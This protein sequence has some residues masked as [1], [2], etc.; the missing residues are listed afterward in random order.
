VSAIASFYVLPAE[1]LTDIVA[2]AT[3]APGG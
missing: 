1:R 3:P 2:A